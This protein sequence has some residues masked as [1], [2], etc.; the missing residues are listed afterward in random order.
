MPSRNITNIFT[1][2]VTLTWLSVGMSLDILILI[3]NVEREITAE[4]KIELFN[5]MIAGGSLYLTNI[6][7][8]EGRD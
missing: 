7:I 1:Y 2:I 4:E 8:D 3:F 6:K 5:S